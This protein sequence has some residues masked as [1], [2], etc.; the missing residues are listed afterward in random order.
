MILS[1]MEQIVQED[2]RRIETNSLGKG[3]KKVD[4]RNADRNVLPAGLPIGA[5]TTR[6]TGEF[7]KRARIIRIRVTETVRQINCHFHNGTV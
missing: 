5:E 1:S 4:T 3:R 2:R 7:P 6:R